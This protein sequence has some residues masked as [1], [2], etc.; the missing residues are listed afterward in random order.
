MLRE[1]LFKAREYQQAVDAANGDKS[2]MP[3]FDMKMDALLPVMRREIPLK[4]HAHRADDIFTAIRICNE[5]NLK[6]TM[7]HCTE[8]YLV[9]DE[10]AKEGKPAIVGPGLTARSKV[11]LRNSTWKNAKILSDAGIKIA[12]MT[13]APVVPL[14][15]LAMSAGQAIGGRAGRRNR[16]EGYYHQRG[17]NCGIADRVGSL[18]AGKDAD[19][20]IFKGN[21]VLEMNC[22]TVMTIINGQIVY[23]N[24]ELA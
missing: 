7:E 22:Q 13:D 12:I 17:R 15:Y 6:M 23:K 5:F 20:V 1:T 18:E 4:C 16:L 24:E 9:A 8:G 11:E 2:K 21:P 19:V 14:K 3:K 10:L